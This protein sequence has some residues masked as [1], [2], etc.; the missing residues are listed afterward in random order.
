MDASMDEG[1]SRQLGLGGCCTMKTV[2]KDHLYN[3]IYY[4]WFIQ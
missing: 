4:L 1:F 2:Y 3:E